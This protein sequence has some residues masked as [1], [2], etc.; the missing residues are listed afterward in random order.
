M[1]HNKGGNVEK[2]GYCCFGWKACLSCPTTT[3]TLVVPSALQSYPSIQRGPPVHPAPP[4]FIFTVVVTDTLRLTIKMFSLFVRYSN[5]VGVQLMKEQAGFAYCEKGSDGPTQ[6]QMK[7][8]NTGQN[9][10]VLL[11]FPYPESLSAGV[12][13]KQTVLDRRSRRQTLR[14][15]RTVCARRILSRGGWHDRVTD[16]NLHFSGS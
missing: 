14:G 7:T 10:H 16:G 9:P 4:T 5:K 6:I 13:P 2:E 15:R 12:H 3:H 1:S 11:S 8:L